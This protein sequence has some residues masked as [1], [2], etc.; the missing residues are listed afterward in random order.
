MSAAY[1]GT[2]SRTRW[3][4][5]PA[6]AVA[7][8]AAIH[9]TLALMLLP[10]SAHPYDI[11]A[12][13]G[14]SEAWLRWGTP[15]LLSWKFGLLLSAMGV[16]A[17]GLRT[18]L[19]HLGLAGVVAAH[20]A[21]KLPL[22]LATVAT[23]GLLLRLGRLTRVARPEIA[24]VI[25]LLSPA[26]LWV[27]A[28]HGQ[29]E[30]LAALSITAALVLALSGHPFASGF[31]IGV[32][33]GIEYVPV[34]AV[35]AI[36]VW[37]FRR[38]ISAKDVARVAL[39]LL[40]G[41]TVSFAPLLV[42]S[43]ARNSLLGGLRS[44][45]TV[46]GSVVAAPS[47]WT[48]FPSLPGAAWIGVV[49]GVGVA[50]TALVATKR[51]SVE[52]IE[53][54]G[55]VP[56][57]AILV[58]APLLNPN[59][60]P[61]FAVLTLLG[62]ILLAF[63]YELPGFVWLAPIA[64]L[65]SGFAYVYGGN[66]SSYWYDLWYKDG[67]SGWTFPTSL[68]AAQ[69]LARV[70]VVVILLC[71][72]WAMFNALRLRRSGTSTRARTWITAAGATLG[73]FLAVWSVQP[74]Y[75]H[76][77]GHGGPT[78]LADY[79]NVVARHAG[80]IARGRV[81][82]DAT[83]RRA[84]AR[85]EIKPHAE[86]QFLASPLAADT[87][88]TDA[89]PVATQSETVRL[90]NWSSVRHSVSAVW[91]TVLLRNALWRAPGYVVPP[92]P[93]L[94]IGRQRIS[95]SRPEF[96]TTG[97]AKLSYSVPSSYVPSS[98]VLVLRFRVPRRSQG[99]VWNGGR[100]HRWITVYPKAGRVKIRLRYR[101]RRVGYLATPT[102]SGT[103]ALRRWEG[104]LASLRSPPGLD[105]R[106]TGASLVWGNAGLESRLGWRT[107]TAIGLV[108]LA[109]ASGLVFV[110][111]V[112]LAREAAY[113]RAG[114]GREALL[115]QDA[116]ALGREP[117]RVGAVAA[118]TDRAGRPAPSRAPPALASDVRHRADDVLERRQS[119]AEEL[120]HRVEQNRE[121]LAS[122]VESLRTMMTEVRG[123]MQSLL[124]GARHHVPDAELPAQTEQEPSRPSDD[125]EEH[126]GDL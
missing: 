77:L 75:W 60:L 109:A 11:E 21:W 64:A 29:L 30:S 95:V 38:A 71:L 51:T 96:V 41:L 108:Y 43:I 116:A 63:R 81:A 42:D 121:E 32:G 70:V 4:S 125:P 20:I 122:E 52:E 39:G 85:S 123:S 87:I 86:I 102:G 24:P 80:T 100:T 79:R 31:V 13:T 91:A 50:V 68:T 58:A 90:S 115:R 66:F 62:L 25:W 84:V 72:V 74:T 76:D 23:A 107:L 16:G 55:L 119:A 101:Y 57:G 88:A 98:G 78:E 105:F 103:I 82:F 33:V 69:I 65:A 120:R 83:L 112:L 113:A 26:P 9:L 27:A 110:V 67:R 37:A 10:G 6:H 124:L 15:L 49:C 7:S 18:V 59:S 8:A 40:L 19:T 44:T 1:S 14:Q 99:L 47:L 118:A 35:A 104:G 48:L 22:V 97:W 34:V 111:L 2:S 45:A 117:P 53:V 17:Q 36:V 46:S 93:V 56:T 92:F 73:G 61:Q 126:R 3:L 5:N 106:L 12:L 28:G 54:D 94:I 89:K 114:D